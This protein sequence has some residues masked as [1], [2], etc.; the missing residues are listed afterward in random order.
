MSLIERCDGRTR[1]SM[2]VLPHADSGASTRTARNW[3]VP[4]PSASETGG[5][6]P[7]RSRTNGI[8]ELLYILPVYI[9]CHS[10]L[11]F[12]PIYTKIGS[13]DQ[14]P[15]MKI[16]AILKLIDL[17][18]FEIFD[19][20]MQILWPHCHTAIFPTRWGFVFMLASKYE[21]YT[22]T[23]DWVVF[24]RIRYMTLWPWPLT[25]WPL[26]HVALCRLGGQ[27]LYQVWNGYD[28]PFQS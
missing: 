5:A 24:N 25:F 16:C 26:G 2:L 17:S 19:H 13:C 14:D 18:V 11:D 20:K 22:T 12:W 1:P 3:F 23:E 9:M 10:G 7:S 27:S 6:A 4:A 15:M 21:H 28:L 8:M